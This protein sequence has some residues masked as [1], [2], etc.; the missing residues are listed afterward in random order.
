M[1]AKLH[2]DGDVVRKLCEEMEETMIPLEEDMN[3]AVKRLQSEGTNP[4]WRRTVIRCFFP[5]IEALLW[6]M[7]QIAPKLALI[8]GVTLNDEELANAKGKEWVMTSKGKVERTLKF[9]ENVKA[10]FALFAKL[11]GMPVTIKFDSEFDAFCATYN[12][13]NRLMHPRKPSDLDVSDSQMATAQVGVA[14]FVQSY[15]R[16]TNP[17]H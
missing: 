8:T 17:I 1:D 6:H 15:D 13:R 2:R 4:F 7:K 16:L 14:W 10:S 12:L 5:T 9:R 11:H 3:F